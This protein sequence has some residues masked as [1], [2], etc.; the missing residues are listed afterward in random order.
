MVAAALVAFLLTA[1]LVP[2]VEVGLRRRNIVDHPTSRSSHDRPTLRGG[3]VAPAAAVLV[4]LGTGAAVGP[5]RARLALGVTAALFGLIGLADD[6]SDLGALRCLGL[7]GAAAT[8][9]AVLVVGLL[10]WPVWAAA[11]A[12]VWLVSFANAFNFMDGINGISCACAVV[13]G[14]AWCVIGRVEDVPVLAG[15]GALIA[16]AALGFAPFNVPHARLFLGD[17][18]S[19]FLGSWLALLAALG[20]RAG[21]APEAVLS[22]L[23]LYLADTGTTLAR[24][25]AGGRRWTD[26]HR[27]HAYQRLVASGWSHLTTT[28]VVGVAMAAS[29]ALGMLALAGSTAL[30][31]AGDLG[32]V[33]VV[34]SY[35]WA[36]GRLPA[37]HRPGPEPA[38]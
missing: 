1:A 33:A 2:L 19:Y 36:G 6:V 25:V 18:G 9:A 37:G 7:Q 21:I 17:V 10:D 15:G 22:P 27:E 11:L 14:A 38:A 13:A 29:A 8:A 32:V 28:T 16:A 23:L 34:A 5:G 24:R 31:V 35:L 3:G 4:A 20:L 26:A 30:R 12:A